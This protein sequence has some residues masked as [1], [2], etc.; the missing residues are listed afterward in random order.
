MEALVT[1]SSGALRGER[2]GALRHF[3]GVPF[4]A[5]A[6]FAAPGPVPAWSGVRDATQHGAV[7]PQLPSPLEIAMGPMRMPALESDDCLTLTI[8]APEAAATPRPVMVWIHGGAYIVGSG[9]SDWYDASNIA[10]EGG[11]VVVNVNYRLGVLGF[12]RAPGVSPG[13]LGLLDQIAAL[14]WVQQN[15]AAFGGDPRCVTLFGESA[16]GH[17]IAAL[18]S[19]DE[20]HGLF[21]RAIIQS[22]H[23]GA[24]FT[25]RA[26]AASVGREFQRALGTRDPHTATLGELK[27][28]QARVLKRSAGPAGVN[29]VPAFGPVAGTAPLTAAK[30]LTRSPSQLHP[31]IAL[32][33]GSNRNEMYSL[34]AASPAFAALRR[35]PWIGRGAFNLVS[36]LA[37]RAVFVRPARQLADAQARAGADVFTYRFDWGQR[38]QPFGACHTIDLP[39][40]F[41]VQSAWLGAPMLEGVAWE[42]VAALGRE[43]RRAWTSFARSGDPGLGAAQPWPKHVPGAALGRTFADD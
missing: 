4:A 34:F 35:V 20:T 13:N 15:I 8:V 24:G 28:A 16:G 1:T 6:R 21:Q 39:V 30:S 2:V 42:R 11:V 38:N 40:L 43:M 7:C 18:L 17:A 5:A 12:L 3:R 19:S 9:S 33:I 27:A 32:L 23:L 22:A 37:R 25:S 31:E 10:A 41:G 26:V 36:E 29:P 14:R